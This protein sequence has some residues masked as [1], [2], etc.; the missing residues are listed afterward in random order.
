MIDPRGTVCYRLLVEPEKGSGLGN[1]VYVG[2]DVKDA[3]ELGQLLFS[4]LPRRVSE[5]RKELG[6]ACILT[7]H[8]FEPAGP[9]TAREL[10]SAMATT[11]PYAPLLVKG[12]ELLDA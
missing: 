10:A 12:K 8:T 3:D 1:T 4:G 7:G 5:I 6:F 11:R 9:T 2:L